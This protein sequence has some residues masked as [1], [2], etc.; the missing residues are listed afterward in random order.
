MADHVPL[1]RKLAPAEAKALGTAEGSVPE[2]LIGKTNRELWEKYGLAVA[3]AV[4]P[5]DAVRPPR[6]NGLLG[7]PTK[8]SQPEVLLY[9]TRSTELKRFRLVAVGTDKK[10]VAEAPPMD[11]KKGWNLI[12]LTVGEDRRSFL[13]FGGDASTGGKK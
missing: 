1:R 3:G 6:I 7:S 8:Y 2:E 12:T 11:L 4:A 13:V 10:K 5:A 9:P